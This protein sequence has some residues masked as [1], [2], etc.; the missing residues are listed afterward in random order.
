MNKKEKGFYRC[1][2]QMKI[3]ENQVDYK[4]NQLDICLKPNFDCVYL[5]TTDRLIE[6]LSQMN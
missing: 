5:T 1:L 2:S 6:V 4:Y 3:C